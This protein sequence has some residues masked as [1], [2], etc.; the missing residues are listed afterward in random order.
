[1]KKH[2]FL[3]SKV[4]HFIR[5]H[6]FIFNYKTREFLNNCTSITIF[7]NPNQNNYSTRIIS[8][9]DGTHHC[10]GGS[11]PLCFI[12]QISRLL[13]SI[14][15]A[16]PDFKEDVFPKISKKIKYHK[17]AEQFYEANAQK[18]ITKFIC[19]IIPNR[20]NSGYKTNLTWKKKMNYVLMIKIVI[21]SFFEKISNGL[22]L[23][24]KFL[25]LKKSNNTQYRSSE[26]YTI[27]T[28]HEECE[29]IESILINPANGNPMLGNSGIDICGNPYGMNNDL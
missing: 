19:K 27:Y 23:F 11:V 15:F 7:K 28:N 8:N 16:E 20:I 24:D 4:F 1:M 12:M 3:P 25:D 6:G 29:E 2:G 5:A 21:S 22:D 9:Y 18:N 10:Y 14:K 13:A 17:I 26:G